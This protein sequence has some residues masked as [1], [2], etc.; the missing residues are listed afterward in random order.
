MMSSLH[1]LKGMWSS[2]NFLSFLFHTFIFQLFHN[3]HSTWLVKNR[4]GLHRLAKTSHWNLQFVMPV[5]AQDILPHIQ[6]PPQQV[7]ESKGGSTASPSTSQ[8]RPIQIFNLRR[9][10]A[11]IIADVRARAPWYLCDWTDAWNYRVVPATAL[12]FF[13]KWVSMS[14]PKYILTETGCVLASSLESP[15]L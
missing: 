5:L 12:T 2:L 1:P 6:E 14:T 15:F 9:L 10:G 11:G 8:P 7:I 3:T 4:W 13:S